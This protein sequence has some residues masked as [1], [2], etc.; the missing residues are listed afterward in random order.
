MESSRVW[1]EINS[2]V[3]WSLKLL[4]CENSCEFCSTA[5]VANSVAW[6]AAV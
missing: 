2:E 5:V 3:V 6:I 1:V 4:K